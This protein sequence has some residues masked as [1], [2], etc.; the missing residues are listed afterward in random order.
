MN[1]PK[2]HEDA[3]EPRVSPV[4]SETQH[5]RVELDR[6]CWYTFDPHWLT[7]AE[8]DDANDRLTA[9]SEWVQR[10]INARGKEV[11]QPRL[12]DWSGEIPYRYSGQTL[13][14]RPFPELISELNRKASETAG[15]EFNHVLLN[16]YRD[17]RDSIAMHADNEPELGWEPVI[18][19]LSLGATRKFIIQHKKKRSWRR[20]VMLTHGSLLVMGG[21]FQRRWRHSV[22]RQGPV[23]E[24]RIN[25]TFRRLMGAPGWRP[26]K[27]VYPKPAD[28]K[29]G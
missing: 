4:D 12:M 7:G 10:A 2:I 19:S 26:P 29:K 6:A 1:E 16:L 27:P 15:E 9:D 20:T 22:P 14:P 13:E 18:A 3:E 5:V 25:V 23:D 17:G 8:A 24:P 28:P 11:M 21:A